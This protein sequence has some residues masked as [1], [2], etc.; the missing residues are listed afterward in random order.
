MNSTCGHAYE[1]MYISMCILVYIVKFTLNHRA[2]PLSCASVY[3]YQCLYVPVSI[4]ASVYTYQCL[5]VHTRPTQSVK[6]MFM[7]VPLQV[8][9]FHE[10]L[11]LI[12]QYKYSKS[13]SGDFNSPES[14]PPHKIMRYWFNHSIWLGFSFRYDHARQAEM[15]CTTVVPVSKGHL[16]G[17][18]P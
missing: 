1:C 14:D 2:T 18:S 16:G 9:L 6:C 4:R 11:L 10:S 3:T 15:V 12:V 8:N 13:S 7:Y 5:Y 17:G